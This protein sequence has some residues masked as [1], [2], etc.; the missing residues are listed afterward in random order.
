MTKKEKEKDSRSTRRNV[1]NEYEWASREPERVLPKVEAVPR[2]EEIRFGAVLPI[3][4]YTKR[5]LDPTQSR[6]SAASVYG[7]E[8][9]KFLKVPRTKFADHEINE[10]ELERYMGI[11][12]RVFNSHLIGEDTAAIR[13]ATALM[14]EGETIEVLRTIYERVHAALG[15]GYRNW[16][17]IVRFDPSLK[18]RYEK[19]RPERRKISERLFGRYVEEYERLVQSIRVKA[20][21]RVP[22]NRNIS[23]FDYIQVEVR[24]S[25]I[26][27]VETRRALCKKYI[28]AI[29]QHVLITLGGNPRFKKYSVPTS[30]LKVEK[31]TLGRDAT[32]Y[33]TLGVKNKREEEN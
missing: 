27:P 29:G 25:S 17:S 16:D 8:D 31:A 1:M 13:M 5:G 11:G 6:I 21:E 30:I 24:L 26:L 19:K 33:V 4:A 7:F 28:R 22:E 15:H 20:I 9:G 10:I 12:D 14:E 3:Y 23:T 32:L 2:G 18:K